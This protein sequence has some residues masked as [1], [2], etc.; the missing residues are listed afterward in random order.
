[1]LATER[2]CFGIQTHGISYRIQSPT[3]WACFSVTNARSNTMNILGEVHSNSARTTQS[4]L[5]NQKSSNH[6][7]AIRTKLTEK[8]NTKIC[9]PPSIAAPKRYYKKKLNF[10]KTYIFRHYTYVIFPEPPGAVSS[11]VKVRSQSD[12]HPGVDVPVRPTSQI[13]D[14]TF[15]KRKQIRKLDI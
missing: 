11:D 3:R 14:I 10:W 2:A 8:I 12:R 13:T 7:S 9:A 6:F 5:E 15:L 4:K 1:M